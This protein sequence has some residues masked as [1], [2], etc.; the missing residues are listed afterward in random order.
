M[1]T[2]KKAV[3]DLAKF[4]QLEG[5]FDGVIGFSGGS[6]LAATL[7]VQERRNPPFKVAVFF[8]AVPALEPFALSQGVEKPLRAGS[9]PLICIPTAHIWGKNDVDW[10]GAPEEIFRLCAAGR[11]SYVHDLGH[12]IPG[13]KDKATII[14][15]AHAVRRAINAALAA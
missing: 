5:P 9:D 11:Q 4:V 1:A 12:E 13:G 2:R 7:L 3:E 6:A 15:V 10:A 14:A 8:S